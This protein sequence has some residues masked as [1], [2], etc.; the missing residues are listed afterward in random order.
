MASPECTPA[1]AAS[2]CPAA[3]SSCFPHRTLPV[4]GRSLWSPGA[5]KVDGES[6]RPSAGTG[7]TRVGLSAACQEIQQGGCVEV[8]VPSKELLYQWHA[9]VTEN[10]PGRRVGLLGDGRRSRLAAVDILITIV[11][12][13][14]RSAGRFGWPPRPS[15]CRR[16]PSLRDGMQCSSLGRDCLRCLT[17]AQRDIRALRRWSS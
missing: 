6:W 14:E 9:S 7:K 2:S 3:I 4:A 15:H 10:L 12:G 5:T 13:A 1:F 8:I 16:V 17:R 11:N